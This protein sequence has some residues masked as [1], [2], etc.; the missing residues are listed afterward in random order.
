[1]FV[2]D[3]CGA[4]DT[5]TM[6]VHVENI[7]H[8][9]VADAGPDITVKEGQTV[10]LSCSA[11]DPDGDAITYWWEIACDEGSLDNKYAL[12]PYFTAPMIDGC[13]GKDIQLTLFVKDAC[14][15]IDTDTMVVHVENVN[16]PPTVK[17]DP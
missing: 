4:I 1:L 12:H 10:Q 13:E 17:A 2:K 7:N 16:H 9:P 15:A 5:D 6:V 8:P 3:A 11:Y 14:G